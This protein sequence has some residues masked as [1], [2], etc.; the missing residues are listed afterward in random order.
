MNTIDIT[1][2]KKIPIF[3]GL[4]D[5]QLARVMRIMNVQSVDT[6]ASI[7]RE[8]EHGTDM[9]ILLA[10]EV[11]V[12]KTLLLKIAGRGL[13]QRDKMLQK[14]S[15]NDYAFFGEMGLFDERSERSASIIAL[16]PCDIAVITKEDFFRLAEGDTAIGYA[17]LKNIVRILSVRLEKNNRD[18]LKLTT[19]LSL[20]LER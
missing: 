15:A 17:I 2:L 19:A 3:T 18:V 9:F 8:H 1:F 11:E 20:A 14:L 13:D 16:T 10:G 4:T 7:I 6:G 12:S 5:D